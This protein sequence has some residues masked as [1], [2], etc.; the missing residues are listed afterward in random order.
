M[1][2]AK[3]IKITSTADL[4]A[5]RI[6]LT[7]PAGQLEIRVCVGG[8]CLASGSREV[9]DALRMALKIHG[10][11]K[12]VCIRETGCMGPC[13][14]GPVL[15]VN[16]DQT[17]YQGVK[18]EDAEAI[19]CEHLVGGKP[20]EHLL[21]RDDQTNAVQRTCSEIP[22]FSR[23]TKVALRTCGNVDP[24]KI[25][26]AVSAGAY[27]ALAKVLDDMKATDVLDQ[28]Q[29]SGLRGRGGAGFPTHLKWMLTRQ[30]PSEKKYVL[31]NG[32]EGDP[33][34][35]MDRSV[36]EGDPHSVIEGM[37]IAA[38]TIGADEGFVYVRAE[39]PLA[40][41]R[42]QLAIDQAREH[43][44]LGKKILGSNFSFDL[45]IRMGSGAFVCGE[46]TALITSIEGKRGEPR[47]RP[48]FPAQKGLWGKPTLLN[49]VETYACIPPI[50]SNGGEWFASMG[51]PKSKGTK[52]FALAGAVK[53]TGLVEVPMGTSLGEVVYDIGGG[54]RGDKAFKAA[55]LGG[56]SGGCI[57]RQN[58]NVPLDYEK[59][60]ELGAIMGSGGLIVMDEDTCMVDVA[61]FFIEF[62][63]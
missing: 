55:Q 7:P 54:I 38:F 18:P 37:A 9:E 3:L 12:K 40:V 53:N 10:L 36:L 51:T 4:K 20:V 24:E 33:G 62:V 32:D 57:P 23:Q 2:A 5:W 22:F 60:Q 44:L 19:V 47:P 14:R 52:V 49:N 21:V 25:E 17:F 13:V 30:T 31:C 45:D 58:L 11:D 35:Y 41:K 63:Q 16:S 1:S 34:A 26:D 28:L 59:L 15:L 43:G 48:P 56:P 39:Y 6:K 46:E 42:L 61:R 8:S 29:A 50:I 27:S